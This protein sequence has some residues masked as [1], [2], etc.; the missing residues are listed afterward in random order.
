MPRRQSKIELNFFPFLSILCGLIAILVLFMMIIMTTRVIEETAV[1]GVAPPSSPPKTVPRP[2][3]DGIPKEDYEKIQAEIDRLA[4]TLIERQQELEELARKRD[5]LRDLIETK[6]LEMV[7]IPRGKSNKWGPPG[8]PTL[9]DVVPDAEGKGRRKTPIFV[10]CRAEGYLVQPDGDTYPA[11][12]A[13]PDEL[14]IPSPELTKFLDGVR[15]RSLTEYIVML[16]HPNGVET[17][18]A[19][20]R[21]LDSESYKTIN[22][23]K[24]PFSTEW[25]FSK[26][27]K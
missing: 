14:P 15:K 23:G 16:V 1:A 22:K 4:G 24:E 21:L 18:T 7:A 17:F 13:S 27:K 19:L 10:E 9:V 2:L 3:E 6:K 8:E 20:E 11:M 25:Q 5:E 12:T 26:P